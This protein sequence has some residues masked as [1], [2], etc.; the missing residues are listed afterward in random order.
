MTDSFDIK[1]LGTAKIPTPLKLLNPEVNFSFV[2]DEQRVL[3][4]VGLP[5]K[6]PDITFEKAGPREK[7]YF[8]PS[9]TR[10]AIVT[11]GGLC[12]GI[13]NVIRT[14]VM[15]MHYNYKVHTVLGFRY[16]YEGFIA[17]YGHPVVELTPDKVK[18]IHLEG[19]S[20]LASSRG[21]QSV[22]EMVDCLERTNINILFVIGG[23]GTLK[24]G[25][26]IQQEITKRGLNI[27]I[28]GLPKTIDNDILYCSKTFGFETAFG[29]AVEAIQSAHVEANG[30]YNGVVL[31]KLMGRDS[32]FIAANT[33]LANPDVNFVLVPE[34]DFELEGENGFL[35]TIENYL[36]RKKKANQHPHAV[37]AVAEG[38]GQ[39]FFQSSDE[40]DASGNVRYGD[41]GAFLRDKIKDY[42][43]D[44]P[45][46]ISLKYI[47]PSYMIRSLPA[48]AHDSIFCHHL[49]ENAVHA[50]MA[51]KT[52]MM[53]GYWNGHHTH[54]PLTQV[55]TG[56][57]RIDPDSELWRHVLY[58]TGQPHNMK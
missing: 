16:G 1:T 48:N 54:V 40:T 46:S 30:Y 39:K 17:K 43:K 5:V 9:K 27:S 24:G 6:D 52:D 34:V 4:D 7:I 19:G 20:F 28:I 37:I 2:S 12:P 56:R 18:H 49:A 23:D 55:I 58:T 32:G 22:S 50:A 25:H 57:K 41:I 26:A 35:R 21:A 31:V 11:C 33:V 42:F 10:A 36:I 53:I 47:E 51:G 13:N 3:Y 38:A 14:L 44:R 45:T 8:D 15:Q 29:K